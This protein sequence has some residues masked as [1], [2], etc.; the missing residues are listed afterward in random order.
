MPATSV[1]FTVAAH[2]MAALGFYHGEEIPS[3]TLAK[4]VNAD[5]HL[6]EE[7]SLETLEGRLDHHNSR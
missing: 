1:Q 3:A 2:I 6:R 7:I 4:S 5:P